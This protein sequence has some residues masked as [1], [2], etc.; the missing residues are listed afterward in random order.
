[1]RDKEGGNRTGRGKSSGHNA[2]LTSVKGNGEGS[3]IV[4]G[5]LQTVMWI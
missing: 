4:Q 1:M 2:D 5:E 3:R